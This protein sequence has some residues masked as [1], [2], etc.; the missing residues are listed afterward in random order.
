MQT[1]KV[2]YF[3]ME[4]ALE[5]AIPT[6]SGGLGAL[7]G[8]TVRAAADEGLPLV[9]M[10]LLY[11]KGYFEQQLDQAGNQSERD[12]SW[13]PEDRLEPIGMVAEVM[14]QGRRVKIQAWRYQVQ[15]LSSRKIPVYLLD[16]DLPE[17]S[18]Y[19][20][21]LTD[22]LYGGDERYRLCQEAIL[23][24]GGIRALERIGYTGVQ[25][26]HLNEGHSALLTLAL[27]ERRLGSADL[28]QASG[29]DIEAIRERCVFTTHTPVPAGHDHFALQLTREV[30]GD[31]LAGT[32]E[33]THCC[34]AGMLNMTYL[35]LRFARY[36]NGVAMHHGEISHDM[37][38]G[39]SIRAITNGVH[40]VT[41]TSPAFRELYDRLTPEWRHDNQ[42]LRYAAGIPLE[43]IQQAHARSKGALLDVVRQR[44]GVQLDPGILTIGFARR[45]T[46]YKRADLIFFDLDRLRE[47]GRA[48][49]LQ[50]LFAGKAHAEDAEGKAMIRRIFE[51]AAKLRGA[52][53]VIYIPGY[54]LQWGQWLTSGADVWLNTPH[55]PFEASGTSG[56]KAALNGVPSLSVPDGWWYEGHFEGTTGWD[57]GHKELPEDHTDEAFSLY[58]KLERVIL[59]LYSG[60]PLAFAEVMRS[61]IALNG[62]F[63]N[64]Q[65]MLSQYKLNAY[66]LGQSTAQPSSPPAAPPTTRA[67]A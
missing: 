39:Y 43:E 63:F 34:P 60:R 1:V 29:A 30:L 41:W 18:A 6:Y 51:A 24:L 19:D 55:R 48:G 35:A 9:A 10:T 12:V 36:I 37:F 25:S 11:R 54:D 23:G 67:A 17:N 5:N 22:H 28:R 33:A 42:Y 15:G 38:P 46:G 45:A 62:S 3:S 4:I 16:T 31:N 64:T 40:A 7:A 61:T 44:M 2:A 65:R 47:I 59:P 58:D 13:R 52:V 32:L 53:E 26:Y 57:I 21:T 27:L 49:R 8:D 56:M 50:L 14:L 66:A 20:R